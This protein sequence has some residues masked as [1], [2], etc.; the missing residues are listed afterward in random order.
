MNVLVEIYE[1]LHNSRINK[2]E[3]ETNRELERNQ[4]M[5]KDMKEKRKTVRNRNN[6][7]DLNY[8]QLTKLTIVLAH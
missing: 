6:N 3:Y 2:R 5:W 8:R 4:Y 1:E 7:I